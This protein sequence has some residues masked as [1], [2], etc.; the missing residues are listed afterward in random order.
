[1]GMPVL[2]SNSL[3]AGGTNVSG[4]IYH[5]SA[6]AMAV[7]RDIDVKSQYDVDYLGTKVSELPSA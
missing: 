5:K 3:D 4:V 6:C 2:M 1:M 7:Q